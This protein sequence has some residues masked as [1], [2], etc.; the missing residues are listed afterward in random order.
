MKSDQQ[1]KPNRLRLG[2]CGS[3]ISPATD[4]VGVEIIEALAQFGFDYIELSLSDLAALPPPAFTRLKQRIER[5]GIP[6]EACNNFFPPRVRLT[7]SEARLPAALDYA[8]AAM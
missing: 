1:T 2:C 3:M 6:C 7:G 8:Q 5:S 4:P